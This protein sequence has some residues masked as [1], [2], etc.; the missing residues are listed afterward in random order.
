[1]APEIIGERANFLHPQH[2]DDFTPLW[3][4]NYPSAT[5]TRYR[6]AKRLGE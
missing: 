2:Y 1:M 4:A 3:W 5:I 6:D